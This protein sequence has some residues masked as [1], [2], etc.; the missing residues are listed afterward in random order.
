MKFVIEGRLPSWQLFYESK[1]WTVRAKLAKTWHVLTV[2][3]LPADY[4]LYTV[5]VDIWVT[6]YYT[7]RA[8]DADNV[9][10]KLVIDGL[11]GKVI[12]DDDPRYVVNVTTR[13]VHY[14]QDL[15]VVDIEESEA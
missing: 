3:A 11:K 2:N 5:P 1:H 6:A 4:Q 12:R 9:C 13:S 14:R 15:V 7:G 8:C 10:A